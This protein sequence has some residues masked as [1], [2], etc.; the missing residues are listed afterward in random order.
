MGPDIARNKV[1]L[2]RDTSQNTQRTTKLPLKSK[3]NIRI[4]TITN[5]A[6]PATIKLELTLDGIHHSLAGFAEC[7]WLLIQ[8]HYQRCAHGASAREQ[9]PRVRQGGVDVR[10]KE[11]GSAS[12]VVVCQRHLEVVHVE[13]KTD[14]HDTDFG[15]YNGFIAR[16]NLLVVVWCDVA[17][18]CGVCAA[19]EWDVLGAELLLNAC[20]TDHVDFALV[21]GE[22][23]DAR[24]VYRGTV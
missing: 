15:V 7:D 21:F 20:L 18:V 2:R 6:G 11:D 10:S 1:L 5:H 3:A 13:I 17:A 4:R 8:H 23:E 16:R 14:E 9:R 24:N 22:L 19:N 12:D